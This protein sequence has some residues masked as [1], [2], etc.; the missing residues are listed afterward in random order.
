MYEPPS[1]VE[2]IEADGQDAADKLTPTKYH[3]ID[4]EGVGV[5]HARRPLPNAVPALAG[6]A[7]SEEYQW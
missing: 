4:V 1:G 6:S 3:E 7:N 2:D 5:I